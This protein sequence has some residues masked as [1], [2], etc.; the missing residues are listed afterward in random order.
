MS[1][2]MPQIYSDGPHSERGY[3]RAHASGGEPSAPLPSGPRP[4][5]R[6]LAEIS[7]SKLNSRPTLKDGLYHQAKS[8]QTSGSLF[9]EA[10][11]SSSSSYLN[12]DDSIEFEDFMAV[13]NEDLLD[14]EPTDEFMDHHGFFYP[15]WNTK[16]K[17]TL[18]CA[19]SKFADKL[20]DIEY[21]EYWDP[22]M[23]SEYSDEFF[24]D[25]RE[26]EFKYAVDPVAIQQ[27][28]SEFTW[29]D[30]KALVQWIIKL[31]YRFRMT[32]ETLYLSVNIVDRFLALK[33]VSPTKNELIGATALFIAA[34]YEEVH[35]P[36]MEQLI[37][38]CGNKFDPNLIREAESYII[39]SLNFELNFAGPL[40][41][42]RRISKADLYDFQIRT[43]AKYFLELTLMDYR[44]IGSPM[45][46]LAVGATYISK[47]LVDPGSRWTD[48]HIFYGGYTEDQLIPL[49]QVIK[50]CCLDYENHHK[51][52]YW[53]YSDK[54]YQKC[55]LYVQ[56]FLS[57]DG[58]S[59][60]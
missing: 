45:S 60:N 3:A 44:F 16:I 11:Q 2:S 30:R 42:L 22:I 7:S 32:L 40:S 54:K 53:K 24:A 4:R 18:E 26:N 41:F 14:E 58:V 46:W 38:C 1:V 6:P 29:D 10:T 43:F 34:K 13:S 19:F 35:P 31:H 57:D 9:E 15:P 8:S 56:K 28:Q 50:E 39:T 52:L 27:T 59:L 20:P 21:E 55:S 51:I 48:E 17:N 37:Y 49:M 25:L 5:M 47:K 12:L 36:N 33:P 23:V